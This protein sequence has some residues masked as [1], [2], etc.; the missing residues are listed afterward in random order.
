MGGLSSF[1]TQAFQILGTAGNI[2][3]AVNQYSNAA[4][5]DRS[6]FMRRQNEITLQGLQDRTALERQTMAL[7]AQNIEKERREALRRAIARQR[8]QYG[9]GGTGSTGGSAQAVLLGLVEE[10][11]DE[12]I[13]RESLDRLRGAS[14]DNQLTQQKRINTLSLTQ[15]RNR[16]SQNRLSAGI[17]LARNVSSLF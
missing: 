6:D 9:G 15:Q 16:E 13:H 7:N 10:S 17:E 4:G 12:R 1:A 5:S 14:L 2:L 3:G 11:E 8:A